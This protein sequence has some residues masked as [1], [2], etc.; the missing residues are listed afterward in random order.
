[1]RIRQFLDPVAQYLWR[2]LV[3]AFVYAAGLVTSRIAFLAAGIRP[4]RM[5]EQADE[6]VAGYYLFTGSLVLAAGLAPMARRIAG[7]Y[8]ARWLILAAFLFVSFG[9]NNSIEDSIYSST[10]GILWM[11]PILLWPCVLLAGALTF[12]FPSPGGDLRPR[13]PAGAPPSEED[14][15][16]ARLDL[17]FKGRP[18]GQWIGRVLGAVAAFP[19]VYFVFGIIVSPIV[20]EYYRQGVSDLVLPAV[21]VILGV[22]FLR[23]LLF[24]LAALPVLWAWSGSRRQLIWFLGLAFFVLGAT[25][26]IV[27]AYQLP[28]VLRVT[29][30]IEI[31]ADSLVYA[32]FLVTLLAQNVERGVEG[33][34]G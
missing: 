26:E 15:P 17:C 14:V 5:P 12:L 13:S 6:S 7:K 23:S 25:F 33:L 27:L 9:V 29:H 8:W 10:E 31:L 34:G 21:E 28:L 2:I 19:V 22:Q 30:S 4:P 1:M 11:I 32:W 18:F 24:L 3:C 16:P 20:G